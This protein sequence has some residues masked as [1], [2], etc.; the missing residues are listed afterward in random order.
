MRPW[1]LVTLARAK[2]DLR[3]DPLDS[4]SDERIAQAI[5]DASSRIAAFLGRPVVYH[6][7]DETH[8]TLASGSWTNGPLTLTSRSGPFTVYVSMSA[9]VAGGTITATGSLRGQ[10]VSEVFVGGL[11]TFY[12]AQIFDSLSSVTIANAA[13]TGTANVWSVPIINAYFSPERGYSHLWLARRPLIEVYDVME[14]ATRSWPS[15]TGLTENVNYTVARRVGRLDRIGV[16]PGVMV[17][18]PEDL[19]LRGARRGQSNLS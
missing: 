17:D 18:F 4:G 7:S 8:L 14:D 11:G 3:A 9:G 6:R 5:S 13:G 15:G 19:A 16:G 2:A 1:D 10:T 12:G